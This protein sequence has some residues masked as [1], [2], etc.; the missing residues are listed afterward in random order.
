MVT[1]GDRLVAPGVESAD[2]DR[3]ACRPGDQA[4][5]K[6]ELL[7]LAGQMARALNRNSV[8]VSPT[9]SQMFGR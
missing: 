9:P 2:G 5:V 8:R 1:P 7:V 3:P 4:A 6:G